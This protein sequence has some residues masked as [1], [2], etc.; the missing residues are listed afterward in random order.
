[1]SLS[2]VCEIY[3]LHIQISHEQHRRVV[4]TGQDAFEYIY[5]AMIH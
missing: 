4:V 5:P 3:L 2:A 1:M